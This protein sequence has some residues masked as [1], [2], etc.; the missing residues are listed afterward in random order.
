MQF[1]IR[2]YVRRL[3]GE[4]LLHLCEKKRT[5][6]VKVTQ[7]VREKQ[8]RQCEKKMEMKKENANIS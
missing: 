6:N 3:F 2:T 8:N 5:T 7:F 1:E 4:K